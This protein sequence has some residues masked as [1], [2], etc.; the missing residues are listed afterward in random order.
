MVSKDFEPL[1]VAEQLDAAESG[2]EFGNVI[3]GLF[4]TLDKARDDE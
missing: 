2:E 1:T 3:L 4:R